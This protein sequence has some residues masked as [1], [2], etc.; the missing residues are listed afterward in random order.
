MAMTKRFILSIDGGGVRGLIPVR[1]LETLESRLSQ[2]GVATPFHQIFDLMAGTSTGGLIAAGLSAPRPGGEAG[3]AAA[4]IAELRTFYER[5]SR[6]IFKSSIT[7]RLARTIS[8]PLGLFDETYDARPLEKLLKERFG[9][10]S[11]ASG[12]TRLVLTAYD[13]EHRK[14]VFMTNG[15]EENGGRPDDYYFWQ[16]VRATTAAPSYFEPARIENLSRRTEEAM[17]DG[18]VFMKD[19]AIAAYLETRKLGWDEDEIVILSLGTGRA[20]ERSFAYKDAIGWG[21]LGW[22]QPSKGVPILSILADGQSQTAAYQAAHLF[23]ELPK[24][25]YYRLEADLPAEAE[26]LDNARPG[27]IITLNGAADRV[28]RDNTVFLD[29]FADMLTE[30]VNSP[31]TGADTPD[32]VHAA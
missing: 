2:R 11:M 6:D 30:H 1:I 5:E 23:N 28:I 22:M 21:A 19:P 17:V 13:I 29:T 31:E 16:A 32:L 10:T 20:S 9:W 8:N 12:L 27:N 7:A 3:E 25:S 26:D 24:V 18:G 4:T 15:L 14:A